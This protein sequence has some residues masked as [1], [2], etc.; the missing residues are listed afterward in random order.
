MGNA[1][2]MTTAGVASRQVALSVLAR[3]QG[4]PSQFK[5][6]PEPELLVAV[7]GWTLTQC[8][9]NSPANSY[10]KLVGLQC[11]EGIAET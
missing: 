1:G 8:C 11:G 3:G 6:E 10:S 7:M 2:F 5:E 9:G 4:C